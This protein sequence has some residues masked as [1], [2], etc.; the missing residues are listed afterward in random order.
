M[1]YLSPYT[2][3]DA[4]RLQVP[5]PQPINAPSDRERLTCLFP[6]SLRLSLPD[7]ARASAPANSHGLASGEAKP[8]WYFIERVIFRKELPS[9]LLV[10]SSDFLENP[11][12]K[13]GLNAVGDTPQI[14]TAR[15][16]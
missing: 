11:Y 7:R 4:S 9:N 13:D 10:I 6:G 14:S 2:L 12:T 3:F 5:T 15:P 16:G 1:V 8:G